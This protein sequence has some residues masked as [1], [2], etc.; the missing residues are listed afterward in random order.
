MELPVAKTIE[1]VGIP[2]LR[3][4]TGLPFSTLFRWQ[5]ND[6]IPGQGTNKRLKRELFESAAKVIAEEKGID[7][8]P[9][10]KPKEVARKREMILAANKVDQGA[11]R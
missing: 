9:L 8:P 10:R 6:N 1:K 3:D 7:L 5:Q 4:A 2:A 11:A